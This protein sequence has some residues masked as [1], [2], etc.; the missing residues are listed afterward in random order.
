MSTEPLMSGP[1]AG[2]HNACG[3]VV[4]MA[5]LGTVPAAAMADQ[6]AATATGSRV[7][8]ARFG[9]LNLSTPE[10][11]RAARERLRAAVERVCAEPKSRGL[12]RQPGFAACVDTTMAAHLKLLEDLRQQNQTVSH[13]ETR[14]ANVSLADLDLSTPEG[15]R[16]A[17]ERLAAAARRVCG[18]LAKGQDLL[19]EPSYTTCVRD[20]LARALAQTDALV[21]RATYLALGASR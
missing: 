1:L 2:W 5:L 16:I 7:A 11:M 9:D 6:Q 3:A 20:S 14:A 15:A 19:Y 10:G 18:E 8:D 12:P 17:R 4:V 21:A 13:S